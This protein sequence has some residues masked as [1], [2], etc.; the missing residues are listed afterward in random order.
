M[1]LAEICVQGIITERETEIVKVSALVAKPGHLVVVVI[2]SEGKR[3]PSQ[4]PPKLAGH[5]PVDRGFRRA[6]LVG[7]DSAPTL[8][9]CTA[10]VPELANE[11]GNSTGNQ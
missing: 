9:S 8:R 7:V 3:N 5:D 10:Y 4:A 2:P 6:V 1:C 11:Q